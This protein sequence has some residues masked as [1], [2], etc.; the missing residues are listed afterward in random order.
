MSD[1]S[2][3]KSLASQGYPGLLQVHKHAGE[4]LATLLLRLRDEYGIP[5][6]IPMTYAGRLDPMAEGL[7]VILVGERRHDK[8]LYMGCAKTYRFEILMGIATD[9]LDMLGLVTDTRLGVEVS[10]EQLQKVLQALNMK[11]SWSYPAYSSRTVS[12]VPLFVSAREGSLPT[13]LPVK[14]G[15]ILSSKLRG[16]RTISLNDAVEQ[17]L[18]IIRQVEG[19]FRQDQIIKGWEVFMQ[20][21]ES[22]K[23]QIIS[24][25]ATVTSGVYIRTIAS[26]IGKL[27]G[28]PSL[29]YSIVRTGIERI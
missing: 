9:T 26:E 8:E 23:V 27:L 21:R 2:T 24:C 22:T 6:D 5:H 12:G 19:D 11:T 3:Q 16:I 29:A 17:K 1:N 14:E 28:M 18:D 20:E 7:M 15:N 4:T 25:E 13:E 10:L